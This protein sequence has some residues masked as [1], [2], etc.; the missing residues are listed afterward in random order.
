MRN[1]WIPL[2]AMW[3]WACSSDKAVED[4]ASVE[5][6]EDTCEPGNMPPIAQITSHSDGDYVEDGGYEPYQ[7]R[8]YAGNKDTGW[9]FLMEEHADDAPLR[10]HFY[11][12]FGMHQE[13]F[14][15]LVEQACLAT[16]VN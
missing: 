3:L 13:D 7:K 11:E 8:R 1:L 2:C 12:N 6:T 9:D 4:G 14:Y 16:K 15:E 5:G 10:R